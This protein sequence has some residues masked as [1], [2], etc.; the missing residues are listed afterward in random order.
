MAMEIEKERGAKKGWNK[1]ELGL[2]A[3]ALLFYLFFPLYDGPVWC[4]DSMSY[5]TMDITREPLYPTFLWVFRRLFG[6]GNYL[7]PVVVAQSILAAYA[8]WKLAV[9]VKARKEGGKILSLIALVSQFGVTILCRFVA[10]R[11]SA[12]TDSIMTE[13]LGLSLYVL[14]VLQ[15]YKY[16]IDEKIKNLA[17]TVVYAMLLI[18]LRKQMLITLCLMAAVF[19]LYYLIKEQKG[20]KLL[21]LLA[22]TVGIFAACRFTDKLYNYCVRGVWIEHSGNSMGMLCTLIYT[23]GEEDGALFEDGTLKGMYEEISKEADK[24]G[25]K[26]TYAPKGWVGLSSHYA[27]SYDAIGYGI[28]NPVVQGYIAEHYEY[29]PVEAVLKYDEYCNEMVKTLLGQEKGDLVRVYLSNT[30]KGFV[31]SIAR[32][33]KYLNI[34][35]AASYLLYLGLYLYYVRK[36]GC[37]RE[38]DKTAAFT[39]IVFGGIGVNAMVVGAMIFCQP[40]YMIYSMGLFYTALAVLVYDTLPLPGF[41]MR[42]REK[43]QAAASEMDNI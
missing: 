38:K 26:I 19:V 21:L 8:A 15:L 23:S 37:W 3:A 4:K 43:G 9:T 24:Q 2:L 25:L 7:M 30:W 11:S 22:M 33:N 36:K 20:K 28:I 41:L 12:Y 42:K 14:F 18:N 39:E 13:G 5:A 32:V 10:A 27:D 34:Y 35:A 40:R 16:I 17:G 1:W 31:N 29:T 6:E